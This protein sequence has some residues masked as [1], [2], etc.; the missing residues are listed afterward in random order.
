[1]V[2]IRRAAI[3]LTFGTLLAAAVT[4]GKATKKAEPLNST[5]RKWMRSMSLRDKVAQLVVM[6]IYGEPVHI[7][8]A[9][10]RQYEHYVRDLRVGGLIVTGHVTSGGVHNAEP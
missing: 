7:R 9:H 5:V 6:P 4:P 8:S 10:F 3:A 1:M 2:F